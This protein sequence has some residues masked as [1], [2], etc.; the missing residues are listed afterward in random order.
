LRAIDVVAAVAQIGQTIERHL[1]CLRSATLKLRGKGALWM[2]ELATP[3]QAQDAAFAIYGAGVCV[4]VAGRYI[5]LLPAATIEPD[6]L[7][8]GCAV[9]A[10]GLAQVEARAD[11]SR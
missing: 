11:G 7:E 2:V 9:V 8:R 4:G 3:Q 5:R 10:Q 6:N 1:G